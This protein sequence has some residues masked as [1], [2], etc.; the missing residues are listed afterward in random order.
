MMRLLIVLVALAGCASQET[1]V[2]PGKPTLPLASAAV[3]SDCER[4]K[5]SSQ[6]DKWGF[7]TVKDIRCR[8]GDTLQ[9]PRTVQLAEPK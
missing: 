8:S 6:L 9:K 3:E 7:P 1:D 5:A 4:P 2:V